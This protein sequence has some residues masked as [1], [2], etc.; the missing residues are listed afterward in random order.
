MSSGAVLDFIK[1]ELSPEG[2]KIVEEMGFIPITKRY[3]EEN[4]QAIAI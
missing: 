4:M 1:F 3:V 2:Q